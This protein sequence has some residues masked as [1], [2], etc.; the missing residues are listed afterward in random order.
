MEICVCIKNLHFKLCE[1]KILE[2][3]DITQICFVTIDNSL[4]LCILWCNLKINRMIL[5][6]FQGKPF[7]ISVIQ[8]YAPT[9]NAKE[10]EVKWF[11]EDL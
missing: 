1:L 8:V 3:S 4:T 7:C 10:A 5:V 9:T 11:Y 6:R 2:L